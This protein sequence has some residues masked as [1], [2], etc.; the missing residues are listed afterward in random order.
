MAGLAQRVR[1]GQAD[2]TCTE[3]RDGRVV[4]Q[5]SHGLCGLG[6]ASATTS[7]LRKM[8]APG[9]IVGDSGAVTGAGFVV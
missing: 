6:A 7:G 1:A 5:T 3:D 4:L 8:E 9:V 2:D